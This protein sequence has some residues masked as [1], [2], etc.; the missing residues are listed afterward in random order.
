MLMSYRNDAFVV[1]HTST[2]IIH[3]TGTIVDG[4]MV[5]VTSPVFAST[6]F[7]TRAINLSDKFTVVARVNGSI[8]SDGN[9]KGT[10]VCDDDDVFNMYVKIQ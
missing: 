8:D 7:S 3:T 10:L 5:E 2:C 4:M 6:S 9:L 1:P